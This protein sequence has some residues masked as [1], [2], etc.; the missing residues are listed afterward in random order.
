MIDKDLL[1]LLV[2]PE[3]R[4]PLHLADAQLVDK[5][6]GAIAAGELKNRVGE[7]VTE[8]IEGGLVRK[9]ETLLYPVRDGIP[10]LLVDEAIPLHGVR[11]DDSPE[12][13]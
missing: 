5:L 7:P 6:N 12:S 8:P 11:Q 1:D 10:M 9:D 2:C 3:D 4:T 13:P